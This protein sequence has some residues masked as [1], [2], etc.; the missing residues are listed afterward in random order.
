ML[1]LMNYSHVLVY[2]II[3]I[4]FVMLTVSV[5][6]QIPQFN[7]SKYFALDGSSEDPEREHLTGSLVNSGSNYTQQI[8][9]SDSVHTLPTAAASNTN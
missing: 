7:L 8:D 2:L 3:G 5:V 9:E 6:G 1:F 4:M